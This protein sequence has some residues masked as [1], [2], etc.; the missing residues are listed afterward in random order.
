MSAARNARRREARENRRNLS[1]AGATA[2]D[3]I[4]VN[5]REAF[6][7]KAF[8]SAESADARERA[9]AEF[10]LRGAWAVLS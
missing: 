4:R 6:L 1:S 3:A 2:L 10:M 8:V 5:G 7:E 9:V